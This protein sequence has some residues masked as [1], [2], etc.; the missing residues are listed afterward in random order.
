MIIWTGDNVSHDIWQQN[1]ENQTQNTYDAT[2]DLIKYF[3]DTHIYPMFGTFWTTIYTHFIGNHEPYPADEFDF[4][5]HASD[6]LM[7]KLTDM[8]KG[9]LDEEAL[10]TFSQ[11]SYYSMVNPEH[12]VKVIA[13]NTIACDNN[14]FYLIADPTDP[15]HQVNSLLYNFL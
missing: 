1:E 4:S 13:L 7:E 15:N 10:A 6:G 2:Q 12:N 8:W 5:G 14:D 3:P 11:F 9:W